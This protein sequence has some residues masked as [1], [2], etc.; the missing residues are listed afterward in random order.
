MNLTTDEEIDLIERFEES[1][2]RL[3]KILACGSCGIKTPQRGNPNA[4]HREIKLE[5]L[6]ILQYD[7]DQVKH[8]EEEMTIPSIK[9]PLDSNGNWKDI[10]IWKI[11][12]VCVQ[13]YK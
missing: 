6:S 10:D 7:S 9:I 12:S 13:K 5:Q 1:Q 8:T 2:G 4:L 11:R 3:C